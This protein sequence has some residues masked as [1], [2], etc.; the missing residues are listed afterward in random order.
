MTE[1]EAQI[2]AQQE[3]PDEKP[4]HWGDKFWISHK[5]ERE[6]YVRKLLRNKIQ[7]GEKV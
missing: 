4:K 3:F 2:L 1:Y 6:Q 5:R 7:K